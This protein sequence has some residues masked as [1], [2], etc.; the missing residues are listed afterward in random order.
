MNL[1][2]KW[3]ELRTNANTE[4]LLMTISDIINYY[5]RGRI[6]INPSYQRQFVWSNEQKTKYIESILLKY[7]VPPIITVK[8]ENDNGLYNY[9][10]I[11]GLQR[12]STI[13]EFVKAKSPDGVLIDNKSEPLKKL[14]GANQFIDI[15]GKD[16]EDFKNEDF[17]FIF[18][19]SS[20]L[21]LNLTTPLDDIKYEMFERLNTL[22][23]DLS[24]Q[25]I[26]NSII[27]MKDKDRYLKIARD[28]RE[29]SLTFVTSKLLS[30]SADM[31]YFVE[32]SLIKRYT[33]YIDKITKRIAYLGKMNAKT[34][35]RHFDLLLTS[36]VKLVDIN[37]LYDDLDDYGKFI[38]LNKNLNFKKYDLDKLKTT[39]N[40]IKFFFEILSFIY[41]KDSL[42][43]NE[44]F[45]KENFN[46]NYSDIMKEKLNKNNPNA[47]IRFD[48]A[49]SVVKEMKND[50]KLF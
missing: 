27:A 47:R 12:L 10:V 17:D 39:G 44:N 49:Q 46:T 26:R 16:W 42:I 38:E 18:E 8:T 1:N 25:E 48:L 36:Y 7:P 40:P 31:E 35:T 19:S 28:V 37:E 5:K 15:N 9:E 20:I 3:K 24:P 29:I 45:Y 21:F 11:D 23:T 41:F 4:H 33:E 22:S 50:Y 2:A 14:V 43:V 32:F 13:F 34:A 30:K 6:N